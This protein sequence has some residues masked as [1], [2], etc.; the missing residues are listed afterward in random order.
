[1][2]NVQ[3][4]NTL[5]TNMPDHSRIWIFQSVEALTPDKYVETLPGLLAFIGKWTSHGAPVRGLAGV[6][7][8]HFLI[9]TADEREVSVGGCSGD[10]LYQAVQAYGTH[11]GLNWMERLQI[12]VW[13]EGQVRFRTR[14]QILE[15]IGS[16]DLPEDVQIFDHTVR[17]L[18]EWRQRWLAPVADSWMARF[19][20]AKQA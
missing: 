1:M 8:G 11:T 7:A 9:F 14:G 16:G 20:P 17:N 2:V 4:R 13:M 19:L 10:A 15:A 5:F 6:V 12:P 3:D 18:G